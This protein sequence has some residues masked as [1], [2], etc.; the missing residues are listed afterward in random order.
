MK[1]LAWLEPGIYGAVIGAAIVCIGGFTL[2]L[3]ARI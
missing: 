2:G 3:S 1:I